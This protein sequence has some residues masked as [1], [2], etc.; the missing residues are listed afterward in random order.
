MRG[1]PGRPRSLVLGGAH[2]ATGPGFVGVVWRVHNS[3]MAQGTQWQLEGPVAGE[4]T[5]GASFAGL[6]GGG[7]LEEE[8]FLSGT[9]T[10]YQHREGGDQP[11]DQASYATRIVVRRPADPAA[12]NG[13]ALVEWFNVSGGADGAPDWMMT[14][15][16]VM[17]SGVAWIGV[18]AQ[19]VGIEGGGLLGAGVGLRE[20]NP[21]RYGSLHHPGDAY[22]FD[23][24]SHAGQA[25][26]DPKTHLLGGLVPT[27]V[28]AIGESQSA[29]FLVTY[30]NHIDPHAR[31]YDGF[32][33]HGRGS[34][35]A[36]LDGAGLRR[37]MSP[38][39]G[40]PAD[41]ERVMA[42]WRARGGEPIAEPRVPVITVQSETD[43][44][45]SFGILARC[46][47]G[48]RTRIWEIA[49]SA[50]FETY[51]LAA[52]QED[53][54]TLDIE[55]LAALLAPTDAPL[56]ITAE[57]PVNSGPQQ[58]YVLQAAL[59]HL[60][61]WVDGGD[62][63]P[64]AALLETTG[65]GDEV[66]LARDQHGNARGGI[67]SPWV[68]VPTAVLSGMGAKGEGFTRLFGVTRP[69]DATTLAAL[70]PG[71]RDQYLQQF[72]AAAAAAAAAGFLLEEDLAEIVALGGASYPR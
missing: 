11:F 54:G 27:R 1:A 41:V 19:A 49:G 8:F 72:S 56:G 16:Q 36:D 32:I 68:D 13:T 31:V 21:D 64:H 5:L 50:H 55:R 6:A 47:D 29:M 46:D 67:R 48:P 30:V 28:L 60:E 33:V 39:G 40:D 26:K 57:E 53:D 58:H 15:R 51:G 9:A 42:E 59:A 14:H 70:Y 10:S 34:R 65:D 3:A 45:Q 17:R 18:S 43:V 66:A 62:P 71:G 52:A 24:Y 25:V 7:Y 22:S 4:P 23:I 20:A 38:S 2:E 61:R 35:G 44:L 12:C 69:F 37:R 63:A